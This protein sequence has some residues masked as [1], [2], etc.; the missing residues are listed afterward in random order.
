[1]FATQVKGQALS[2]KYP[3]DS[4]ILLNHSKTDVEANGKIALVYCKAIEDDYEGNCTIRKCEIEENKKSG[5]L[6]ADK[7]LLLNPLNES[8]EAIIIEDITEWDVEIVGVEYV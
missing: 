1:M 4:W 6:F 8:V 7:S 5:K 2:P 3:H